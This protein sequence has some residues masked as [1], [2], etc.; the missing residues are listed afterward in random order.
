MI[1]QPITMERRA[2]RQSSTTSYLRSTS[3]GSSRRTCW[4][5]PNRILERTV[6]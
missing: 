5:R 3:S 6:V 4:H 1:I 2:S